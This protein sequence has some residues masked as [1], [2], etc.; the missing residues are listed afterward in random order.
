MYSLTE[1]RTIVLGKGTK[2]TKIQTLV[3]SGI[4]LNDAERYYTEVTYRNRVTPDKNTIGV[5]LELSNCNVE[6][7]IRDCDSLGISTND[8]RNNYN[9]RDSKTQYKIM[10]DASLTRDGENGTCEIVSPILN[11]LAS[12]RK[13]CKVLN[14]QN[15]SVNSSCGMHIHVGAQK[16]TKEQ[17]C[18]I[19]INYGKVEKAI[20]SF[21]P[22]SRRRNN[23][24]YTKSIKPVSE[25]IE[26]ILQSQS[27]DSI[28]LSE[29]TNTRYLKVNLQALNV[30]NTI[31]FRQHS[32]TINFNKIKNWVEFIISLV[33]Y[34]KHNKI[35]REIENIEDI[36][37]IDEK[38]KTF[39]QSRKNELIN[40]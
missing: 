39:F 15:A 25:R 2:K 35:D 5:E 40:A 37:F 21:M 29:L 18:N 31:E 36:P 12:L 3:S 33:N 17:I 11:N 19:V 24:Y 27:Y 28:R 38:Q 8:S 34:S 10:T 9:H 13:I 16:M 7:F 32:G 4:S 14:E 20:D 23:N 22:N 6:D 30:H 26:E 1:I